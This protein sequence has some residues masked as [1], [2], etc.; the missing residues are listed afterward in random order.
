MKWSA[1]V[2]V[3]WNK[4]WNWQD[5]WEWA[6]KWPEVKAA[7]STMGDWDACLW[8]EA[9]GPDDLEK[10]VKENLWKENWVEKTHTTWVKD[11][12]WKAA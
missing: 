10:F 1:H 9:N 12:W 2:W 6:E 5:K 8:V 4:N 7:W 3:R 11:M